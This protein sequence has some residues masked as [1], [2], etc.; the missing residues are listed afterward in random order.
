MI[1]DAS[2][3]LREGIQQA[4]S[5]SRTS[6]RGRRDPPRLNNPSSPTQPAVLGF[7]AAKGL[8]RSFCE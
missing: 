8:R 5:G 2:K 4:A 3:G 7:F 1:G 6:K